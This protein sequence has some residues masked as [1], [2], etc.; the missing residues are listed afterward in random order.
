MLYVHVPFCRSFC[1]YC[2]FYSEAACRGRDGEAISAWADGVCA[3]AAARADEIRA[4]LELNTLYIGGGTPSVLPADV[5]E[6]VVNA[7]KSITGTPYDEFTV[8]VNPD[9]I[10]EKG[11]HFVRALAG[12]GVS[13]ISMGV[14]SLDDGMLRWM[15]RRHDAAGARRAVEIIR[16]SAPA[17]GLCVDLISGVPGMDLP[18]LRKTLEEVL[19][20]RPEHISAYQLGIDEDSE[21]FAMVEDGRVKEADE[22]ECRVQYDYLCSALREAGYH[23]YEISNWAIPGHEAR[24][25]SAYWTRR[26]YVGLGPGAHSLAISPDGTQRRSWNTKTLRGWT[27]EGEVLSEREIREEETMLLARTDRGP[28]PERDWFV[29][30]D[31]IAGMI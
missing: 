23:H 17:A 7:M 28:I 16:S 10:V 25:N 26:P 21:L 4:T 20:W 9:D 2:G 31:I 14:Q 8:E 5:L 12:M 19:A 30:D 29:A 13:R 6:R 22:E 3:E 18:M 15:N 24:H 27:S 1:L 11:E